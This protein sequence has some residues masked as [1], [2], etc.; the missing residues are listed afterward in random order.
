MHA[1]KNCGQKI[2]LWY[3]N[4]S[5]KLSLI[6]FTLSDGLLYQHYSYI[7]QHLK[8]LFRAPTKHYVYHAIVAWEV[9]H[10]ICGYFRAMMLY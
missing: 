8:Y 5:M 3:V 2:P 4:N 9:T 1:N 6:I 7:M 10:A